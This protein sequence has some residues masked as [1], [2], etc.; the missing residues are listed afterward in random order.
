MLDADASLFTEASMGLDSM[1][2]HTSAASPTKQ[3]G[4]TFLNGSYI[5]RSE[6]ESQ[7]TFTNGPYMSREEHERADAK[8]AR[9]KFLHGPFV[10]TFGT[11]HKGSTRAAWGKDSP[12]MFLNAE[13]PHITSNPNTA[14]WG[15]TGIVPK[16]WV[17]FKEDHKE[18]WVGPAWKKI[19][20]TE[21]RNNIVMPPPLLTTRSPTRR[22]TLGTLHKTLF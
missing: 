12:R 15:L 5:E 17:L 4:S 2:S 3:T 19:A 18:K 6:L 14:N 20:P 10:A 11:P 13:G 22:S 8:A 1:A 9:A 7:S 16:D 21:K